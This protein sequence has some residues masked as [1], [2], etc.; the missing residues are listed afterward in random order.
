MSK[1]KSKPKAQ[2]IN[3]SGADTF[4][5]LGG[6]SAPEPPTSQD[7]PA[8]AG[9]SDIPA[10]VVKEGVRQAEAGAAFFGKKLVDCTREELYGAIIL[11]WYRA[12]EM[13]MQ[14]AQEALK[15]MEENGDL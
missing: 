11:T 13:T 12:H 4:G 2:T 14:Y 15:E 1:P 5:P 7:P 8:A 10:E 9:G 6:A 3:A